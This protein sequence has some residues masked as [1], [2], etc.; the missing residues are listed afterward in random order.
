MKNNKLKWSISWVV[1]WIIFWLT[2][3]SYLPQHPHVP[4]SGLISPIVA[5][6]AIASGDPMFTL[7]LFY[8]L[9]LPSIVFWITFVCILVLKKNKP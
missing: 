7:P 4:F 5:P 6:L 8:Q 3:G 2:I 1:V 9:Y